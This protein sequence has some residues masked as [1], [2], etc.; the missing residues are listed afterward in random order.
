M[1]LRFMGK[2][3]FIISP[4]VTAA[5]IREG[6]IDKPPSGKRD[7]R[8]IQAAFNAWSEESGCDLTTVS[9]TLAMSIDG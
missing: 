4:S 9:R 3:A 2:P 7:Y 5:L 6:V 8:A 1:F